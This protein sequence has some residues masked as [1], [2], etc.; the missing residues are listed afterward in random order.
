MDGNTTNVEEEEFIEALKDEMPEV[1]TNIKVNFNQIDKIDQLLKDVKL[2]KSIDA[3]GQLKKEID[4]VTQKIEQSEGLV[5]KLENEIIEWDAFKKL[6]RRDEELE[7]IETRVWELTHDLNVEDKNVEEGLIKKKEEHSK[8]GDKNCDIDYL[9]ENVEKF[10]REI[11]ELQEEIADL[12]DRR[13]KLFDEFDPELPYTV[14]NERTKRE[15]NKGRKSALG[16][17]GA[18]KNMNKGKDYGYQGEITPYYMIS[19]NCR[20]KKP[21]FALL[22]AI[23]G[24]S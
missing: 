11:K 10:R 14:R 19:V 18:A 16:P 17:R 23:R 6:C 12:G 20:Y 24:L 8:T 2:T 15:K 22:K 21:I 3:M 1:F 9:E 5:N 13:E 7:E 4:D